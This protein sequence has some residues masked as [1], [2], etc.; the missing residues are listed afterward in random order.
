MLDFEEIVSSSD[1]SQSM[2]DE[3]SEL[4]YFEVVTYKDLL[5][6]IASHAC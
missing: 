4:P 2:A 3:T 1:D 6:S 5:S